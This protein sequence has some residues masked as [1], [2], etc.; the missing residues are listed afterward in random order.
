MKNNQNNTR[1]NFIDNENM[2]R[3]DLIKPSEKLVKAFQDNRKY[4]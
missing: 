2:F 3:R 1:N 4:A